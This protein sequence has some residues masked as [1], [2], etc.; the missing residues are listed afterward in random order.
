MLKGSTETNLSHKMTFARAAHLL[1]CP[2]C[3][4]T[5]G[6]GLE[7][8]L[9]LA[10][11]NAKLKFRAPKRFHRS[12]SA[13]QIHQAAKEQRKRLRAEDEVALGRSTVFHG[14]KLIRG[15]A[16]VRDPH[17]IPLF[18]VD[19][20]HL[21]LDPRLALYGMDDPEAVDVAPS[22][23]SAKSFSIVSRNR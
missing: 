3:T 1:A 4:Q 14:R 21:P 2:G 9:V 13:K 6:R 11:R 7:A 20:D 17:P 8:K 22:S 10:A 5:D 18:S 23:S 12:E 19:P 15:K 16:P